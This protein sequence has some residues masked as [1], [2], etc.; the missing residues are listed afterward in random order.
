MTADR[1]SKLSQQQTNN[2]GGC[3]E[4]EVTRDGTR[5][6]L[7]VGVDAVTGAG[8]RRTVEPPSADVMRIATPYVH[9]HVAEFPVIVTLEEIRPT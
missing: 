4:P 2:H 9:M 1:S 6:P 7:L 5:R 8:G 3:G